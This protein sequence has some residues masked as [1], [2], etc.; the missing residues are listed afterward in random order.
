MS[1][2]TCPINP[3]QHQDPY[4]AMMFIYQLTHES[5]KSVAEIEARAYN[6]H[7]NENF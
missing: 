6:E 1:I 4:E 3:D 5:L 2:P 7:S